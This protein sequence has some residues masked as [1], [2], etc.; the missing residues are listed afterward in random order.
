VADCNALDVA[1]RPR[2]SAVVRVAEESDR[3]ILERAR[4][5]AFSAR[6]IGYIKF[7]DARGKWRGRGASALA[8]KLYKVLRQPVALLVSRDDGAK[9]LIIRTRGRGAYRVA[10]GMMKMGLAENIGGHSGLAVVKLKDDV[11]LEELEKA[12]RRLSLNL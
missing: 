2:P 5:L 1:F 8:S 6:R 11:G 12:L 7:V 10:V 3:R 9:L 4:D